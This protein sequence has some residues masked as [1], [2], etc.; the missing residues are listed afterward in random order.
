MRPGADCRRP[1]RVGLLGLV[2]ALGGVAASV[3]ALVAL[4]GPRAPDPPPAP[5]ASEPDDLLERAMTAYAGTG[6]A[7]VAHVRLGADRVVVQ[8][9]GL[10]APEAVE[11][12]RGELT[13]GV[14]GRSPYPALVRLA[15]TG[16]EEVLVD[17][18]TAPGLVAFTGD[19]VVAGE[20]LAEVVLGLGPLR[21]QVVRGA[22][23]L[24]T[25]LRD[26]ETSAARLL[27]PLPIRQREAVLVGRVAL[28]PPDTAPAVLVL[29][30]A[31]APEQ[32]ARLTT[33]VEHPDVFVVVVCLGDSDRA[34]WR[35]R[36][37]A[38]GEVELDVL[39]VRGRARHLTAGRSAPPRHGRRARR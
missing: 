37:S 17:L 2:L 28:V 6:S 36:C 23:E 29:A 1:A 20:V 22:E 13:A 8:P 5:R 24:E 26:L 31:P 11:L 10:P 14:A 4:L 34:R 38:D 33:L 3:V 19:P 27:R 25:A 39:G 9:A 18:A 32:A 15:R 7:P 30:E 16:D 35:V 21:P 12:R